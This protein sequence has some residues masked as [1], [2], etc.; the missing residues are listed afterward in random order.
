MNTFCASA[1]YL[2]HLYWLVFHSPACIFFRKIVPLGSQPLRLR[3]HAWRCISMSLGL[4]FWTKWQPNLTRHCYRTWAEHWSPFIYHHLQPC[5]TES[6]LLTSSF[7]TGAPLLYLTA[8]T[9]GLHCL[10]CIGGY[11]AHHVLCCFGS[12]SPVQC[13][14]RGEKVGDDQPCAVVCCIV[15]VQLFLSKNF[16]RE[17]AFFLAYATRSSFHAAWA[18]A[19]CPHRYD[20]LAPLRSV[21]YLR[22]T[23]PD[24]AILPCECA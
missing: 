24:V 4:F 19:R 10:H 15:H 1:P 9:Y 6:S 23:L 11:P 8:A 17:S 3:L 14:L 18:Q 13:H 22:S 20:S 16:L 7:T 5:I 12:L 21:S 2:N